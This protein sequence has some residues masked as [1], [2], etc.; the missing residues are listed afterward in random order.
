MRLL[1]KQWI[2]SSCFGILSDFFIIRELT[3]A[4][5]IYSKLSFKVAHMSCYVFS[6]PYWIPTV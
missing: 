2:Y 4:V 5:N 1:E 6:F 3:Q